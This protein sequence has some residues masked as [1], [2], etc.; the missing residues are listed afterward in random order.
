MIIMGDKKKHITAIM[1]PDSEA[2]A[3]KKDSEPGD[4]EMHAV[5]SELIDAVHAKD[6]KAVAVALRAAY[7]LC[8]SYADAQGESEEIE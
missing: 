1:G 6:E 5:S 4:E 2:S 8:D 3:E 7:E